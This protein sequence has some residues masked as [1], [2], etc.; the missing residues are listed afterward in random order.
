MVAHCAGAP[1]LSLRLFSED[2]QVG[3]PAASL[4]LL[5]SVSSLPNLFLSCCIS[6]HSSFGSLNSTLSQF[7]CFFS[8]SW[9]FPSSRYLPYS[10]CLIHRASRTFPCSDKEGIEASYRHEVLSEYLI[11]IFNLEIFF[12][13]FFFW[14]GNVNFSV[15][16][17]INMSNQGCFPSLA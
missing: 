15:Y 16:S 4:L 11:I 8:H 14:W 17:L 5:Q 12:D 10:L 6:P 13:F 3:Q 9:F 7:C 1:T 2:W